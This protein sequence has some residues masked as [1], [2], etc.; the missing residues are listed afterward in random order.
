MLHSCLSGRG[1]IPKAWHGIVW[2]DLIAG[3]GGNLESKGAAG[4]G[5]GSGNGTNY[6]MEA[7]KIWERVNRQGKSPPAQPSTST[8]MLTDGRKWVGGKAM[9]L[10]ARL[11][12][13]I[14]QDFSV[15]L[16]S[17]ELATLVHC[18]SSDKSKVRQ[19]RGSYPTP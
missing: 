1:L 18:F 11:R 10:P 15:R 8:T 2:Y 9:M 17:V 19:D 6:P 16:S 7:V 4:N 3:G 5:S 12:E 14:M 13:R